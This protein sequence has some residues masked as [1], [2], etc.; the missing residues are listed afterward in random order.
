MQIRWLNTLPE[1]PQEFLHYSKKVLKLPFEDAFKIFYITLR[2]ESLSESPIY[3]FLERLPWGVK[4][5]ELKK[6]QYLL[7]LSISTL[8]ELFQEHLDL[9]LVKNLYLLL[10]KELPKDF[11]KGASPK[12]SIVASQDI[13]VSLLREKDKAELPAFLKAKHQILAF[14]LE[15]ECEKLLEVASEFLN[16]WC[17]KKTSE[18][19]EVF[20]S[21]S[22][23]E[24]VFF[25]LK[26]KKKE[27]EREQV[28]GLL[29]SVKALF[30]ECFGEI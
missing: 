7:S 16:P 20:T 17:L 2:L 28:E 11:L 3:K 5:D 30:P 22:I 6:R 10:S 1:D 25:S 13:A 12:H 9:R 19:I 24:F 27:I 26:L 21:F 8:R 14:R 18:G 29:E 23:S 15:G 4:F